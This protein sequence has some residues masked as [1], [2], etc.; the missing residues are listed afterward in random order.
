MI[1]MQQKDF[2][3]HSNNLAKKPLDSKALRVSHFQ[4]GDKSQAPLDQYETTY[5]NTMKH[6]TNGKENA[7]SNKN[8]VSNII[9]NSETKNSYNTE[10]RSK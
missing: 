4:L 3:D 2:I 9:M 1:S 10:T 6:Q 8:W 7:V 5:G